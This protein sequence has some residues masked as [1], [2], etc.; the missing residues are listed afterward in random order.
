MFAS[1]KEHQNTVGVPV[2]IPRVLGTDGSG[3]SV[4]AKVAVSP[5]RNFNTEFLTNATDA[6]Q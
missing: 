3:K 5:D 4:E 1:A 6:R 2:R